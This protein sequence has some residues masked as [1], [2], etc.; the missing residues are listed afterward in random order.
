MMR[1]T[2][3]NRLKRETAQNGKRLNGSDDVFVFVRGRAMDQLKAVQHEGSGGQAA[4]ERRVLHG[5]LVASPKR[6]YASER[7]E[8]FGIRDPR[9]SLV[10]VAADDGVHELACPL[11]HRVRVCA[12]ADQIAEANRTIVLP[13]GHLDA[14]LQGFEIGVNVAQDQI[15]QAQ[16]RLIVR[17]YRILPLRSGFENYSG[18]RYHLGVAPA[19]IVRANGG[20]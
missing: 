10:V 5:E 13:L 17:L 11:R 3:K 20:P 1:V 8:I 12:V 6:A 14:F 18:F 19:G 9:A 7:V 2:K 16:L 15:A 4:K